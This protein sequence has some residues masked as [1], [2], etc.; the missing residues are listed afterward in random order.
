M[1]KIDITGVPETMIQTLYARAKESQKEQHKIYD[2]KAIEIVSNLDYDFSNADKD[3]AMSSGVISRTI[4]LDKLVKKYIEKNPNALVINIA[5]GMDTRFYRVDNGKVSWYNI[6]LPVTIDVRKK[7]LE[8]NGRVSMI[9]KSAMDETWADDIPKTNSPVLVII[10]GL[11]MYLTEKDVKKIL[12]IIEKNFSNVTL[13]ME[14]MSP[15]V[16]KNVKEK[17]IDA[18]NAKF[19]WGIKKGKELEEYN[20]KYKFVEDI[21]LTEG[22]KEIY[23][24]YKVIGKIGFIKNISN[25]ITIMTKN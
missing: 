5:C 9:A 19:T 6:D 25:K 8:E 14:T 21:S 24:V 10:E 12:S 16:V 4:I 3:F 11:L 13:Y 15:L 7:F 20:S 1:E 22:M 17:S 2:K 18:S 23:P